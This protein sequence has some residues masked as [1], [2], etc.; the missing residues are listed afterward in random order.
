MSNI[1]PTTSVYIFF[2]DPRY[3]RVWVAN[4][5][6]LR[7]KYGDLVLVPEL[8]NEARFAK[9]FPY[10][11]AVIA[12]RRFNTEHVLNPDI[13]QA[14]FTLV[15]SNSAEEIAF[16]PTTSA[17]DK[18]GRVIMHYRGLLVR[19]GYDVNTG[20]CWYVKFP[21]QTVESVRGD[22]PEAAV[23]KVF[24]RNLQNLAEKYTP[25]EPPVPPAATT[26]SYESARVRPGSLD[27]I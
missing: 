13:Y 1:S 10:E 19:P 20:R 15:A 14:R 8:D 27:E 3:G 21:N 11:S 23:D 22:S 5:K 12:A 25:T 17:P 24:E 2:T 4:T 16:G 26:N 18:D 6:L 9:S 7:N